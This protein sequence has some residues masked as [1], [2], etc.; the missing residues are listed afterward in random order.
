MRIIDPGLPGDIG[1]GSVPVV[2]KHGIPST[3]QAAGA[4]LDVQPTVSA[5]GRL[6]KARQGIEKKIDVVGDHQ[7]QKS[8]VVVVSEGSAG[9]VG[10]H[11]GKRPQD[12]RLKRVLRVPK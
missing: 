7:I 10:G 12:I 9:R 5:D 4:A 11:I 2:V 3:F 1:E 6:A 8:V